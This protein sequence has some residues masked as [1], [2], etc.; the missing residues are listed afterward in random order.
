MQIND[1]SSV[2]DSSS[3]MDETLMNENEPKETHSAQ[4]EKE[5]Q[6]TISTTRKMKQLADQTKDFIYKV[7]DE[8]NMEAVK[9]WNE[10]PM[11]IYDE[12]EKLSENMS[13]V[14]K[15]HY[16][17][18]RELEEEAKRMKGEQEIMF[19]NSYMETVTTAFADELDDIRQGNVS[20]EVITKKKKGKKGGGSDSVK[21]EDVI[22]NILDQDNI[23]LA[24]PQ[25]AENNVFDID[26]MVSCLESGMSIWREEEKELFLLDREEEHIMDEEDTMTKGRGL[27]IH[28]RR[29]VDLF[30]SSL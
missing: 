11:E 23:I 21:N 19:K 29:R 5:T 16:Q 13:T 22:D 15:E 1:D 25:V 7:Q 18:K 17:M 10:K 20:N 27:S 8:E 30:G 6:L 28:E 26:V 24:Q 12:I 2:G 4:K 3:V 9:L 14:W